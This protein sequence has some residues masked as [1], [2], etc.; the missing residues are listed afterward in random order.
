MQLS[1]FSRDGAGGFGDVFALHRWYQLSMLGAYLREGI[2]SRRAVFELSMR[3]LPRARR[4]LLV[5]G[6]DRALRYLENVRFTASE[7]AYLRESSSLRDVMT[8]AM[9][10]YLENFRFT[11]SV[12]GLREGETL[13][14]GSAHLARRRHARQRGADRRDVSARRDQSRVESG[15]EGR[16]RGARREGAAGDGVRRAKARPARGADRGARCVRRGVHR[17]SCEEAGFR[18]GVPVSGTCARSYM[19]AHVDGGE[20]GAFQSFAQA[21]PAERRCSSTRGTPFAAPFARPTRAPR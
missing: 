2:A 5:A 18:Y 1:I 21:F 15:F 7:I 14:G 13:H 3:K 19:L 9:V 11:G 8:D 12:Y 4:F 16:A 17:G 20:E 10:A 6:I